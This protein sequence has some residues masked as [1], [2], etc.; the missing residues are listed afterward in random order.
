MGPDY[1]VDLSSLGGGGEVAQAQRVDEVGDVMYIGTAAPG[2]LE[3]AASWAIRRV[4]FTYVGVETDID[5]EWAD[6]DSVADK[7]WDDR[8]TYTYS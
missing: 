5:T 7:I 3:S 6:G 2:S 4:T 8:L 1:S